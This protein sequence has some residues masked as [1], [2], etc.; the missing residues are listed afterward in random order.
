MAGPEKRFEE[1]IK[2][3]LTERGHYVLKYWGGGQYT[4]AGVPDL[5]CCVNG[6]FVAI[7]V[8]AERGRVSP[9][10]EHH[11][12]EIEKAGGVALVVRPSDWDYLCSLIERLERM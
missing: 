10:Q 6:R 2:R 8:K 1:K 7:E 3:F 12:G 9:L 4:K 11:I 5:L